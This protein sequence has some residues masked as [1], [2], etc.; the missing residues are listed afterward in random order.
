MNPDQA[1]AATRKAVISLGSAFLQC[2]M[3]LRRAREL[4]LTGWA[5]YVAGRGG[6]LGDVRPDTVASALGMISPEAVRDGW[7]AARSV[8]TP[9]KVAAHVLAECSRWGADKL[10]DAPKIARLVTLAETVAVSADAAGMPLFAAWRAMP[11]PSG[12]ASL[13]GLTSGPLDGPGARAAIAMHLLHEHRAGALLVAVR[14]SG[15][16]PVQAL[17]AGPEGEASA[18]A[19]GWQPPY[20]PIGPLIRRRAWADSVADHLAGQA[21][22]VLSPAERTEFVTLVNEARKHAKLS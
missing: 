2:P 18:V 16:T 21:L 14:A 12:R 19:Y 5:F 8:L 7:T 13:D 15:L 9:S 17:I 22:K 6:A 10:E 4:G 1:G 3:T 11:L 20:P